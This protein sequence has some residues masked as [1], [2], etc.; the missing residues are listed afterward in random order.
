MN[1]YWTLCH[2]EIKDLPFKLNCDNIIDNLI[3]LHNI[4]VMILLNR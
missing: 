1:V 2:N 4:Y 3:V